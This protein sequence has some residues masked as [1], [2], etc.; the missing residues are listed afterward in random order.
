MIFKN[1]LDEINSRSEP[2]EEN[3]SNLDDIAMET[4][5]NETE[6]KNNWKKWTAS[7]IFGT[8]SSGLIYVWLES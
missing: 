4:I 8:T 5:Q 3:I 7:M 1:T 2:L 6:G